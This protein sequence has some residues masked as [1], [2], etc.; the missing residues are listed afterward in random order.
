MEVDNDRLTDDERMD[1]D[2]QDL[3]AGG[4]VKD[5][6]G[7]AVMIADGEEY[8]VEE[9]EADGVG[10]MEAEPIISSE[11]INTTTELP[12]PATTDPNPFL[13]TPPLSDPFQTGNPFA[14]TAK[15]L[16]SPPAPETEMTPVHEEEGVPTTAVGGEAL[17]AEEMSGR[18]S[19]GNHFDTVTAPF[20]AP[21]P[22]ATTHIESE[23]TTEPESVPPLVTVLEP[24]T[25][26]AVAESSTMGAPREP[27]P[28]VS[29]A[30]EEADAAVHETDHVEVGD[31]DEGAED[32]DEA[33]YYEDEAEHDE[34]V[35]SEGE[36]GGEL[37]QHGDV[38]YDGA[39]AEDDSEEDY[40]I[41]AD[42]LPPIIL[43]LPSSLGART[44]FAPLESDPGQLPIWLKGRQAELAEA[45]LSDVW[46]AIRAECAKEGIVKNGGMIIT[47]TQMDLRMNEDDV[48]L[49]SI[50]FL[51]L[52][53]LYQGCGLPT[54][55]QLHLSWET[56]RFITRFNAIQEELDAVN[57][58]RSESAELQDE[59]VNVDGDEAGEEQGGED[60]E[61]LGL[62]EFEEVIEDRYESEPGA[63]G[64]TP[65]EGEGDEVVYNEE[66]EE[67]EE[68][69]AGE[70]YEGGEQQLESKHNE[71][72]KKADGAKQE[73]FDDDVKGDTAQEGDND[74][75]IQNA[76]YHRDDNSAEHGTAHEGLQRGAEEAN[77]VASFYNDHTQRGTLAGGLAQGGDDEVDQP[78]EHPDEASKEDDREQREG[79]VSGS[80]EAEEN[81]ESDFVQ[82]TQTDMAD[83]TPI[84][85][86]PRAELPVHEAQ[87]ETEYEDEERAEQAT[88]D[89]KVDEKVSPIDDS[90]N[91][92]EIALS[93]PDP[94]ETVET[95]IATNDT[96]EQATGRSSLS[97]SEYQKAIGVAN[98]ALGMAPIP[99]VQ[100]AEDEVPL[101]EVEEEGTLIEKEQGVVDAVPDGLAEGGN[102][103]ELVGDYRSGEIG[104]ATEE[105]YPEDGES[106]NP[107]IVKQV[108]ELRI[109]VDDYEGRDTRIGNP[110]DTYEGG[111]EDD[112]D[113][114]GIYDDDD[115]TY[116]DEDREYEGSGSTEDT[117]EDDED[118]SAGTGPASG[119]G[120]DTG[121]EVY[122]SSGV[123][124]DVGATSRVPKRVLRDD[125]DEGDLD[126]KRARTGR[127]ADPE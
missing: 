115:P 88:E 4:S 121:E 14:M 96:A 78:A 79:D 21:L 39:E 110:T 9:G 47:E 44:L 90:V 34:Q 20:T 71:Y 8:V 94:N 72:E 35:E 65:A 37:D 30:E 38:L 50:T 111:E 108:I 45:S 42:S 97:P 77:D 104:G 41:D 24:Q 109:L 93:R 73:V 26:H 105:D 83:S 107:Q 125:E 12:I 120:F 48:N 87:G 75:D 92:N 116:E 16:E 101:D 63:N 10:E 18:V 33:E 43:H 126:S 91:D 89:A 36:I 98:R 119:L 22:P 127:M 54:P 99:E 15:P 123:V 80:G 28:A 17:P 82:D 51:E 3:P 76:K 2:Y 70:V 58:R 27:T 85:A 95:G 68:E 122:E 53:L 31:E 61:N 6:D 13:S 69:E 57:I 25:D 64:E 55:V 86:E 29:D 32:G 60:D 81:I 106:T 40:P 52:I 46:S 59:V 102:I 11:S 66:E 67:Y 114:E 23:T 74:A 117:L 112:I 7:D 124:E 113:A 84:S 19:T 118:P 1:E 49:Q 56:S 100:D 62:G 5:D 103:T